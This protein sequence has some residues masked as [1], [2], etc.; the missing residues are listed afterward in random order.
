[1]TTPVLPPAPRWLLVLLWVATWLGYA[2]YFQGQWIYGERPIYYVTGDEPHYLVVATSLLRDHDLDVLN[3]YRDKDYLSFYPYHLGDARDPEDMHALYGRGGHLYSKHGLGLSLLVLPAFALGGAGT[4]KLFMMAIA[5]LL[6]VQIFLLAR[7]VT[8]RTTVALATWLALSFTAPLLLYAD[9]LYPEVPGALL[10]LVGL[11]ALLHRPVGPGRA[12]VAGVA[13][14]LLPWLHLRYIPLAAVLAAGAL[15]VLL[16]EQPRLLGWAA[17]PA[18]LGGATLLAL[19]W[20]LFGGIPRV[21]EYG[22][23]ALPNLLAGIPGLLFD[24]QYGLLDYAPVYLIALFGLA[25]VPWALAGGRGWLLVALLAI[26]FGFIGSFSFWFGAFSPPARML[27][28]VVPLL[29]APLALALTRWPSRRL[30]LLFAA[31][32]GL[33]WAIAH[34][35][36]DVPRL[37]YNL[38][39]PAG[40]GLPRSELLVYLSRVWGRD[41]VPLLPSFVRPS[42][43]SYLWVGGAII[44]SWLIWRGATWPAGPRRPRAMVLVGAAP[45]AAQP[46]APTASHQRRATAPARPA[47]RA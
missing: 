38:W 22:T 6:S 41:L 3:N 45:R 29:A 44:A 2:A 32:L 43:A 36:M 5:A 1:M 20:R 25:Q 28:P 10:T 33:S 40:G 46:L 16:R 11:R 26:Y 12:L 42:L 47:G 23:V 15:I 8:G 18:L 19:D 4:A 7:E 14:G 9:Q 21:D 39:Q 13:I 30:W 17:L 34:L 37:R 27:V 35:L 24:A 31:T